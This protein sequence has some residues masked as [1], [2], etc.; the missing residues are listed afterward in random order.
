VQPGFT[1]PRLSEPFLSFYPQG[2]ID[3]QLSL[4]E[5]LYVLSF[6]VTIN[7]LWPDPME[8]STST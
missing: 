1:E 5:K 3:E 8:V 4:K 6:G 2:L 7:P